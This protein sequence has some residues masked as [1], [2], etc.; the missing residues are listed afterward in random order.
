MTPYAPLLTHP[1]Y[2]AERSELAPPERGLVHACFY[3]LVIIE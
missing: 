2:L 3:S 1:K